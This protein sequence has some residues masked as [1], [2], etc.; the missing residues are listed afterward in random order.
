MSRWITLLSAFMLVLM[1]WTGSVAHA[2]EQ[3][4]C[5][6]TAGE[7]IGHYEG[8]PDQVP[9]DSDTGVAHHHAGCNGHQLAA[10]TDGDE[11][12]LMLPIRELPFA[13]GNGYVTGRTPD[14][15]LRP[16]IA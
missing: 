9:A 3:L 2:A 15:Q 14:T 1:L 6:P 10:P 4:N 8:D 11:I 12:R 16:P 13:T 5:L 7:A